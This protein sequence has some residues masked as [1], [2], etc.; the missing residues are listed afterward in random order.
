MVA[1][2]ESDAPPPLSTLTSCR[3]HKYSTIPSCP[4]TTML[5]PPIS[6]RIWRVSLSLLSKRCRHA[7]V[8]MDDDPFL[9]LC[10]PGQ[11]GRRG[12]GWNVPSRFSCCI[13]ARCIALHA[14]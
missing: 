11:D 10:Q 5:G 1:I 7:W 14:T 9:D 13:L 2:E 4:W 12:R 8:V 6:S 3:R